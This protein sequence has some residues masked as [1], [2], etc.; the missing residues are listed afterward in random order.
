MEEDFREEIFK[1]ISLLCARC[2]MRDG[3]RPLF[4]ILP[5]TTTHLPFEVGSSA[6]PKQEKGGRKQRGVVRRVQAMFLDISPCPACRNKQEMARRGTMDALNSGDFT[7]FDDEARR[8]LDGEMDIPGT[9]QEIS[10]T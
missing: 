6:A 10:S 9:C 1:K 4:V 3:I 8:I 5:I 7:G 2:G